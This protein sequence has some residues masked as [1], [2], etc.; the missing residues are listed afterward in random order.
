[1]D[2]NTFLS[3]IYDILAQN[4]DLVTQQDRDEVT[5]MIDYVDYDAGEINF[6]TRNTFITLKLIVEDQGR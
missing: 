4:K 3:N 6:V 2:E 1:M 5:R